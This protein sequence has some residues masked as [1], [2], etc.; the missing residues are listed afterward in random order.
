[1]ISYLEENQWLQD[2]GSIDLKPY[3]DRDAVLTVYHEMVLNE[4]ERMK[5]SHE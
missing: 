3:E 1:M 5:K 4:I 2:P